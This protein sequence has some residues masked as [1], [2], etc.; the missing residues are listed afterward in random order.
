MHEPHSFISKRS[1]SN[2]SPSHLSLYCSCYVSLHDG[3]TRTNKIGVMDQW[4]EEDGRDLLAGQP[5]RDQP[6]TLTISEIMCAQVVNSRFWS[7][8]GDARPISDVKDGAD[9]T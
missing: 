6:R 9:V 3:L 1:L 7:L 2:V 5:A 8:Y 4:Y